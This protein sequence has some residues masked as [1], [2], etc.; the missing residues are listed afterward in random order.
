[1]RNSFTLIELLIVVAI[2]AILAGMLLPALNNARETARAISC[3]NNL[4]TIGT[5]N[6]LYSNEYDGNTF[7]SYCNTSGWRWPR[8]VAPY[9]EPSPHL[10]S[11]GLPSGQ[12]FSNKFGCPS[13][14]ALR[15]PDS[16]KTYKIHELSYGVNFQEYANTGSCKYLMH[17]MG[18]IKYP[19]ALFFMGDTTMYNVASNNASLSAY[20]STGESNSTPLVAYRHGRMMNAL[21]FDGHVNKLSEQHL[22]TAP[23]FWYTENDPGLVVIK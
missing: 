11:A 9:L 4:K 10:D 14:A 23:N 20:L 7:I 18:K 2:I 6:S 22:Q 15:K 1:M 8:L 21:F 5:A 3:A 17:K 12:F 19:S 13:S 16:A